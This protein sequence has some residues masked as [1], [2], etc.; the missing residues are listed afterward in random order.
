MPPGTKVRLRWVPG[1][2]VNGGPFKVDGSGTMRA[3]LL[4]VRHD[5][6]GSRE[7]FAKS[8]T[9]AFSDVHGPMLVVER[10]ATA[11]DFLARG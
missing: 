3:P 8:T 2:T 10:L 11:P 1:I 6:L 9:A 7:I 5:Q 4:L